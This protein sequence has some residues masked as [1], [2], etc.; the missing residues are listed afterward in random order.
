M[1]SVSNSTSAA[2]IASG[3][4]GAGYE[5]E[6]AGIGSVVGTSNTGAGLD[7]LFTSYQGTTSGSTAGAGGG[8]YTIGA[9]SP[10][11]GLVTGSPLAVDLAGTARSGTVAAGA[12]V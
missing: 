1:S 7:P 11:K 8:D 4:T 5:Q 2:W 9:L 6:Y 3:T 10:A 12:Y